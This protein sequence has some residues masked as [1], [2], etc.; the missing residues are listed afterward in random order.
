MPQQK[1][2]IPNTANNPKPPAE[3]AHDKSD[4]S[5]NLSNPEGYQTNGFK[6][7]RDLTPI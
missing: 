4:D 6:K 3:P 7:H 1:Q 2:P 5:T